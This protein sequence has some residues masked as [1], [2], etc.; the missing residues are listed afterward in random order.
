ML[1]SCWYGFVELKLLTSEAL[2]IIRV[3]VTVANGSTHDNG[4]VVS[5]GYMLDIREDP[6]VLLLEYIL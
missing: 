1:I 2:Y 6:Y 5:T 3:L 4:G